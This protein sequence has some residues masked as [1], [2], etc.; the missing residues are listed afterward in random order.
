MY[1]GGSK[2]RSRIP[3]TFDQIGCRVGVHWGGRRRVWAGLCLEREGPAV[4]HRAVLPTLNDS[5][6]VLVITDQVHSAA[7][8]STGTEMQTLGPGKGG[9][10][11]FR[12][13]FQAPAPHNGDQVLDPIPAQVGAQLGGSEQVAVGGKDPPG[14]GG[15]ELPPALVG[16]TGPDPRV[17]LR[18]ERMDTNHAQHRNCRRERMSHSPETWP[19]DV[20]STSKECI[21]N[22]MSDRLG[23]GLRPRV[24]E[25]LLGELVDSV[26]QGLHHPIMPRPLSPR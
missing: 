25:G 11:F 24:G 21:L 18:N 22:L 6:Y 9:P 16:N 26:L 7:S 14:A 23:L 8:P 4:G 13:A 10:S 15:Q 1:G 3:R 12:A 17:P 5:P 2:L 20:S 19:A